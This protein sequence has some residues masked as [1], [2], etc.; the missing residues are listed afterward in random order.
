[1]HPAD[2]ALLQECSSPVL[3]AEPGN[4]K[5]RC[6]ADPEVSRGGCLVQTRFGIIDACRETKLEL[7][8]Q[9]LEA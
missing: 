7:I 5:M 8:R 4:S 3:V 9:S 2:F 6:R 1:L